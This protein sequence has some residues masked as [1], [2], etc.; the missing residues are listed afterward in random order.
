MPY[1]KGSI[2]FMGGVVHAEGEN[3]AAPQ[4]W[5]LAA[6]RASRAVSRHP[7]GLCYAAR[8]L[9]ESRF[10]IGAQWRDAFGSMADRFHLPRWTWQAGPTPA[11]AIMHKRHKPKALAIVGVV[12][13]H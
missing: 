11:F 4:L 8:G 7:M 1:P 12:D 2:E 10:F 9:F 3:H 6:V 13:D 5:I